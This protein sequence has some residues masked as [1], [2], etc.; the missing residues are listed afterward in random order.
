[1]RQVGFL[2]CGIGLPIA[3]VAGDMN[4]HR[5]GTPELVR[6]DMTVADAPRLAALI[7]RGL[8]GNEVEVVARDVARGAARL[9]VCILCTGRF[10]R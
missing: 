2:A 8:L 5:I 10:A 6:W 4:G 9:S 3:A 7:A 1:M